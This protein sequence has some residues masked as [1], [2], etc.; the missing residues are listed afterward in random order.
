M[1]I[2]I[3]KSLFKMKSTCNHIIHFLK[4]KNKNINLENYL[5]EDIKIQAEKIEEN[6]EIGEEMSLQ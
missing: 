2:K 3:I 1:E 5:Y 6:E 4:D